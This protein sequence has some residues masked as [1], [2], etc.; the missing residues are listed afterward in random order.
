[1]KKHANMTSPI[2]MTMGTVL[3]ISWMLAG[4]WDILIRTA[5]LCPIV[6]L[7]AQHRNKTDGR[8]KEA[9]TREVMEELVTD[10][11]YAE[12]EQKT[13]DYDKADF[14]ALAVQLNRI[15]TEFAA[16]RD[17]SPD[18]HEAQDLVEKWQTFITVNYYPCDKA[19]LLGLSDAYVEDK[20][21]NAN[22]NQ[23][24]AGTAEFMASATQIY[25]NQA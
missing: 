5:Y 18:S 1:M 17:T 22:I 4:E 20:K 23:S 7:S 8:K 12:F 24:G 10:E 15:M 6:Y 16:I 9:Y 13:I 11:A 19:M 3:L 25:C 21:F 14:D 2:L